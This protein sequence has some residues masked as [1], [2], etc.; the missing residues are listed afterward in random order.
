MALGATIYTFLVT[1]NDADR[2]VYATLDLRVARHPSETGEFLLAR[3]LAHA[4]E[5]AEGLEFSRGGLSDPD[6]PALAIRDLTGALR[7]WIEVGTPDAA[8][9]H[10]AAKAAPRVV[11]YC[12]KDVPALLERLAGATIHRAAEIEIRGIDRALLAGLAAR[13]QRRMSF[14]LS[15]SEGHLYLTLP[16]A[17]LD[18]VVSRHRIGETVPGRAPPIVSRDD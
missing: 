5:H 2:G 14:D 3:V 6:E 1:L 15:V 18:G 10:R 8:R 4:L 17:T 13:L 7:A 9:L 16:D 11:V 12:H